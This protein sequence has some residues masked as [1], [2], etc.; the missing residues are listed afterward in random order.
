MGVTPQPDDGMTYRELSALDA[1]NMRGGAWHRTRTAMVG[2]RVLWQVGRVYAED[3]DSIIKRDIGA[4]IRAQREHVRR[5][6]EDIAHSLEI[7]QHEISRWETGA[8]RPSGRN[9]KRLADELG[10]H[11][12]VLA[13]GVDMSGTPC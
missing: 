3:V 8:V 6:Q 11:W 13:Y 4:R 10:C 7:S 2:G 9:L 12:T 5:S 1:R